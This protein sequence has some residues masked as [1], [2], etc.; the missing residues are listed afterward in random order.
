VSDRPAGDLFLDLIK[1]YPEH[2]ILRLTAYD[3]QVLI[4]KP[5]MLADLLVHR[6][7]DFIKPPK[8][9]GFLRHVLGDGL[10]MVEGDEHKFLRKNSMP[11]F[12]F[13]HIKNLYPMMWSKSVDMCDGLQEALVSGE[14]KGT[15]IIDLSN[16]TSRV[17]LDI[18]GVA[19][20]GRE[21]NTLKN[22]GDPILGIYEQLLEPAP[23][24]LMYAMSSIV[25]GLQFVRILPW[26]MN[27]LFKYLTTTLAQLCMPMLKEKKDAISNAKDDHFDILSLLIKSGNFSDP[28]LRDQLLTFLAAGHETTSSALSWACYLLAKHPELQRT[29]R[30]EIHHALP[31]DMDIKSVDL[32]S[33]LEPLPYLNGIMN[34]TLRLYPTVP[35]TMRQAIRDTDLAGQAIPKGVT[36]VLSTWLMN[37]SPEVWGA[38]AGE[39]RPERWI[40][41]GKPNSNGGAN[42]NYEFL[43]FLHGPRSCIGQGFAKA[44]MR[45]LLASMIRTFSWDLAM[46]ESKILPRG[47]IT[48]KPA[49]GLLLKLKPLRQ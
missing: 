28:Q 42:S 8:I 45:C 26:K 7:Y 39:F 4:T 17:T 19:G 27:S 29:L 15:G 18:I 24:K 32:A 11:A 35:L 30:E 44:E 47:A 38:E 13:R 49:N 43:T 1:K 16:W 40:T 22:A 5:R 10:I 21:F 46:D 48:I 36:V 3:Y 37:R 33:T 12:S 20:M 25:F 6:A 9:S 2:E 31:E 34:E 23:A 41:S 14:G